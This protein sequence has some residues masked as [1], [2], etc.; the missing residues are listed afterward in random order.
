MLNQERVTCAHSRLAVTVEEAANL[1]SLSRAKLYR[2][3]SKG[4][5]RGLKV[6]RSRRIPLRELE[7]FVET[8]MEAA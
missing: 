6:G 3:L 7:R 1:L 5:I 4:E 8:R 2:L